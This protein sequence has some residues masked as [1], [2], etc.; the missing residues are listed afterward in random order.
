MINIFESYADAGQQLPQ[1]DKERFYTALI[2]FIGYG[3]EPELDGPAAAVFT[4]I[5]PTLEKSKK[6]AEAGRA[7]GNATAKNKSCSDFA[8]EQNASKTE[9]TEEANGQAIKNTYTSTHTSA[10]KGVGGAGEGEPESE[11]ICEIV[12]HLNAAVGKS[13]KPTTPKTRTLIKARMREG[14]TVADFKTVIDK[15]AK[16]WLGTEFAQYLRP[17]TLFGT[18]F[19]GYLNEIQA[20]PKTY[21]EVGREKYSQFIR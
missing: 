21:E 18:K 10:S 7:G 17:E 11:A 2:E 9:A 16:A 12:A 4:A 1:R 3:K 20:K 6:R 13:Y 15:K 19:E 8:T 5:R 14:F